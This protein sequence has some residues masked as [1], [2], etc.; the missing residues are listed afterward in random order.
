MKAIAKLTGL[1]DEQSLRRVFLQQLKITPKEYREK[2]GLLRGVRNGHP[3]ADRAADQAVAS[4]SS[5]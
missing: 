5:V 4:L 3:Q 2:F 1:R